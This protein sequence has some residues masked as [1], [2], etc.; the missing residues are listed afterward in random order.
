MSIRLA[1]AGALILNYVVASENIP[2]QMASA[3]VGIDVHPLVFLLYVNLLL[4]FLGALLDA[5]TIPGDPASFLN[6]LPPTRNRPG[7]F[8]RDRGH[9]LHDRS[10]HAALRHT[11]VR[12]QRGN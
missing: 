5:T 9:Q 12:N 8:R 10:D 1:I 3:L 2:N 6:R 7:A 4:L 11:A